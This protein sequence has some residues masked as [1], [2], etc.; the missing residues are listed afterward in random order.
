[1]AIEQGS[2]SGSAA[3]SSPAS[4]GTMESKGRELGRKV[5]EVGDRLAS[6]VRETVHELDTTRHH[7]QERAAD[8]KDKVVTSVQSGRARIND[9]LQANPMRTLLVTAGIGVLAGLLLAR[10]MRK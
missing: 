6:G 4:A 5:D 2:I 8:A 1:M 3:G 7:L 9:E 10:R